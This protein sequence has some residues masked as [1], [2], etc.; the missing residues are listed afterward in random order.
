MLKAAFWIGVVVIALPLATG[1]GG[2]YPVDYDP[3]PIQVQDIAAT[4]QAIAGD[5]MGMC[6]R[7]PEIC[8]TGHRLLWSI[9]G[10]A[11]GVAD[12][13]HIWLSE[14]PPDAEDMGH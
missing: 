14:G 3:E 7:E 13:A 2:G 4:A 11:T 10:A 9:R 1:E 8:D 5:F 6:D 12:K